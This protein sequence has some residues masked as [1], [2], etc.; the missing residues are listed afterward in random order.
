[1]EDVLRRL[2]GL[3]PRWMT[4]GEIASV[5]GQLGNGLHVDPIKEVLGRLVRAGLV[6]R[7]FRFDCPVC[8]IRSHIPFDRSGDAVRC[9]GCRTTHTLLGPKGDEPRLAYALNALLDRVMD[10]DCIGHLLVQMWAERNRGVLWSVPGAILRPH[11]GAGPSREV[12]LFGISRS[13]VVIS[14]VKD[15]AAA[16]VPN[17]VD[18]AVRGAVQAGA[19]MLLVAALDS[20]SDALKARVARRSK[21]FSGEVVFLGAAD[22]LD[23]SA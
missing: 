2:P 21:G 17:E 11:G 22:L 10:Q 20:W 1:M 16:Y 14:E 23:G 6:Y 9:E 7:A 4:A 19:G 12:D 8:G 3:A 15:R 18:K 5:H 13:A